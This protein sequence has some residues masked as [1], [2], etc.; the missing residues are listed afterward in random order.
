[1]QRF[2]FSVLFFEAVFLFK[3]VYENLLT[4]EIIIPTPNV[5]LDIQKYIALGKKTAHHERLA[6]G[7]TVV[8]E[9]TKNGIAVP[10]HFLVSM[11][12]GEYGTYRT[13]IGAEMGMVVG[14]MRDLFSL[15]TDS[16][17]NRGSCRRFAV[18]LELPSMATYISFLHHF[19]NALIHSST[20]L[21]EAGFYQVW[22]VI[23]YK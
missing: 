10:Q 2:W 15:H 22:L 8:K 1:M 20:L 19:Q 13:K 23:M 5:A 9:L 11:T 12:S 17:Y 18:A 7:Y 3:L 14:E 21:R 6:T 16:L 4:S